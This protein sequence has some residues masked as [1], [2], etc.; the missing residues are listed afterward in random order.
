MIRFIGPVLLLCGVWRARDARDARDADA[1]KEVRKFESQSC[2]R[3]PTGN[4]DGR[5]RDGTTALAQSINQFNDG[6]GGGGVDLL[7]TT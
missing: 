1:D 6:R 7:V 5:R 3:L 4:E 2:S